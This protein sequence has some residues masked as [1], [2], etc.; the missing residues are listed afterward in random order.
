MSRV[1]VIAALPDELMALVHGWPRESRNGVKLWRL[2]H[3]ENECIA[4][5]AGVGVDAAARAFAEIEGDGA[6][7]SVVS[8]GWAG[9][10]SGEYAVG[11]AYRVSG[12]IDARTGERFSASAPSRE[13]WLV[14]SARIADQEEKQRLAAA[15][16]AGLVDMEAAG[17]ARLALVRGIPFLCIKGVSDG[18][19]DRLPGFDSFISPNGHFQRSRFIH[20]AILRPWQWPSLL[21]IG[22]N[23]R[24]AARAIGESLISLLDERGDVRTRIGRT[25]PES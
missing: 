9:A 3:G 24:R 23:S 22:G 12:V 8:T 20:S 6:V 16:G 14:T 11:R 10:L 7:D 15:Y 2:R 17:I 5:C 18:L 21:R 13:C 1:A 4:A 19:A 25:S